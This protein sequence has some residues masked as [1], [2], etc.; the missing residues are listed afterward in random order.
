MK[1][2]RGACHFW[3]FLLTPKFLTL[4]GW[5]VDSSCWCIIG[6]TVYPATVHICIRN[7]IPYVCS[8]E[9]ASYKVFRNTC[10]AITVTL[11]NY[12]NGFL[13]SALTHIN[14]FN[15][16]NNL[17]FSVLLLGK[18]RLRDVTQ[19]QNQDS[20]ADSKLALNHCVLFP[21]GPS[22]K[23]IPMFTYVFILHCEEVRAVFLS[24]NS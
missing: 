14:Q 7:I 10:F 11:P 2:R 22:D 16:C 5:F 18:W 17:I 24:Q 21:W 4:W 23:S 3:A 15:T 8:K 1:G 12:K 9:D 13:C 20:N 19:Y 6:N